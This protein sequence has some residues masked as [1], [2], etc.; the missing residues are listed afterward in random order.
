MSQSGDQA[1]TFTAD[2][3]YSQFFGFI[4]PSQ[5]L[6]GFAGVSFKEDRCP[7]IMLMP[8]WHQSATALSALGSEQTAIWS[9]S[10]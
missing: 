5:T 6:Y 4:L 8:K 1:F 7:G 9:N 2:L 3:S 10:W